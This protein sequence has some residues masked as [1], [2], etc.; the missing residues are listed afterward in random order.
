MKQGFKQF[1]SMIFVFVLIFSCPLRIFAE[2]LTDNDQVAVEEDTGQEETIV[3]EIEAL[4]ESDASF[5]DEETDTNVIK[6]DEQ[7]DSEETTSTDI[8]TTSEMESETESEIESETETLEQEMIINLLDDE[9]LVSGKITVD[10][11]IEDWKYVSKRASEDSEIEYWKVAFDKEGNLYLCF[12]GMAASEWYG[13]YQWK[14]ITFYNQYGSDSRQLSGG[15]S[16]ENW[17][18]KVITKNTAHLNSPAPYYVEVSIPHSYFSNKKTLSI[19]FAGV[20]VYFQDIE[21]LD[22]QAV[23]APN[24][25]EEKYQGIIIDGSFTDWKPVAIRN[26]TDTEIAKSAIVFDGDYIYIYLEECGDA[27]VAGSHS[28]GTYAITTDLGYTLKFQLKYPQEVYGISGAK[29]SHVGEK[30][31][32]QITKSKLPAYRQTISF[33][34]Y[35][36]EPW[37]KDV[38]NLDGSGGE[39]ELENGSTNISYDGLFGDWKNYPHTLIQYATPG[40]QDK[41]VDGEAALF[42]D[43][44]T[45][46]GH[47]VT[48]MQAH[49]NEAGGEFTSAI[50]IRFNE[51][52]SMSFYPRFVEVDQNG[53]INWNPKLSGLS[54][55]K[56][57]FYITSSDAWGV[58]QNLNQLNS[59]DTMYGKITISVGATKDET[60]FYLELEK[61]AAKYHCETQ[62][63]KVISAQFGRIGQEWVTTAGASTMPWIIF[64][65]CLLL[66]WVYLLRMLRVSKLFAW[67]FLLG[68]IGLFSFLI[69]LLKDVFMEPFSRC[70]AAL[71]GI[72][73]SLLGAYSTYFKYGIIFIPTNTGSMTLQ[74]DFEC[75]GIIEIFAFLSLLAFFDLYKRHEKVLIGIIGVSYIMIINALRISLIC[76]VVHFFGNDS[77]YIVHTFI[78]RLFFY[79]LSVILYFYVFTKPQTIR[80]KVGNFTYDIHKKIT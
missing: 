27:T 56:H 66:V 69:V 65:I 57:E 3:E 74:I 40:T 23:D 13:N 33:G 49:L 80:M 51:E 1:I 68:S 34:L 41:E 44:S 77:Y 15:W 75:S 58:S 70:V 31:E 61:I 14:T 7:D 38:S 42:C 6:T 21:V 64:S 29:A 25:E 43:G 16:V 50:T 36:Q 32:I 8:E 45:L 26:V 28:N 47:V 5:Y 22:N 60:E 78:G 46:Y 63:L 71:A 37:I 20:K 12:T 59:A 11:E 73:G 79:A 52:P 24:Q 39:G 62:E 76:F 30:W 53:R 72:F 19:Q 10:G 55:G 4:E 17:G 67:R 18:G 54:T 2:E 9:F 48:G 35:M